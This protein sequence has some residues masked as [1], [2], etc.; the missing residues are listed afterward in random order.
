MIYTEVSLLL[1]GGAFCTKEGGWHK[2]ATCESTCVGVTKSAA[3]FAGW[4]R[5]CM[6]KPCTNPLSS[7]GRKDVLLESVSLLRFSFGRGQWPDQRKEAPSET[8]F[9][10]TV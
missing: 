3:Y 9:G 1:Q 6:N 2:L 7:R 8:N 4:M 5:M 10:L